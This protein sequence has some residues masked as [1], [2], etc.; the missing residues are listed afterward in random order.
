MPGLL[1][2][3]PKSREVLEFLA[4]IPARRP[5]G[6]NREY[7][8]AL[9]P[10]L[11][12]ARRKGHGFVKIAEILGRH[13]IVI[14]R[15][16]LERHYRTL[17]TEETVEPNMVSPAE[18]SKE[19]ETQEEP[20]RQEAAQKQPEDSYGFVEGETYRLHVKR[21]DGT[22]RTLIAQYEGFWNGKYSF[23]YQ[24]PTGLRDWTINSA[25][26]KYYEVTRI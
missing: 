9:F 3:V 1:E 17:E 19:P 8:R 2:T 4:R 25:A 10:L 13:G 6:E 16:T 15:S 26:L 24:H 22:E 21:K 12:E 18:A 20:A 14:S 23:T 11:A 5:P 7:V